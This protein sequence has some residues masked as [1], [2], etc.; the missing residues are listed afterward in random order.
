VKKPSIWVILGLAASLD[1]EIEQLDVETTF[2]HGDLEEEIYMDQ[3]QSFKVKGNE[4]MVCKFKMILY[5]SS[6]H[7]DSGIRSLI[8][9]C[10]IM[11]IKEHLQIIVFT[12]KILLIMI[13]LFSN[14]MLMTC[15]WLVKINLKLTG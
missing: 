1:L 14:Y 15:L 8:L 11:D 13:L 12:F 9:S 3:P 4:H 7:L 2:F 10:L 5:G 6:R